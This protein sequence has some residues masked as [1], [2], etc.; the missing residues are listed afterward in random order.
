[1]Y[2]GTPRKPRSVASNA[3]RFAELAS[4][5]FSIP[6]R[7]ASIPGE[8]PPILASGSRIKRQASL[9]LP[10]VG[11]SMFLAVLEVP[12]F[13]VLNVLASPSPGQKIGV[14]QHPSWQKQKVAQAVS[15]NLGW[16]DSFAAELCEG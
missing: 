14:C 4:S 13:F 9:Q 12:F 6:G 8:L 11:L 3:D 7:I 10:L 5:D 1:L 2:F 16:L 15:L